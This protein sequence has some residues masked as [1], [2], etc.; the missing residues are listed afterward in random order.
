MGLVRTVSKL[1]KESSQKAF[2]NKRKFRKQRLATRIC[3]AGRKAFEISSG[4]RGGPTD[5]NVLGFEDPKPVLGCSNYCQKA[6]IIN[7][8]LENFDFSFKRCEGSNFSS[9]QL[10]C[11]PKCLP[12]RLPSVGGIIVMLQSRRS[13]ANNKKYYNIGDLLQQMCAV[14][15]YGRTLS[16]QGLLCRQEVAYGTYQ[17]SDIACIFSPLALCRYFARAVQK[18]ISNWVTSNK[19]NAEQ[20]CRLGPSDC[21]IQSIGN[22]APSHACF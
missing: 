6:Q 20:H 19:G 13:I 5:H 3:T 15:I 14:T 7:E 21:S 17:G 12:C 8:V 11:V 2:S 10:F 16:C 9:Q 1:W 4:A 18:S 22:L